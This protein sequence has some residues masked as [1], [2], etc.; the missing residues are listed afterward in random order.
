M[1]ILIT[2]FSYLPERHGISSV[3]KYLAE[4]LV[5][6]GYEVGVATCQNNQKVGNNE[7]INGVDVHRFA[8]YGNIF[9]KIK[10][11]V[12]SYIKFVKDYGQDVLLME[13][14]QCLTTDVLLPILKDLKCKVVIH[15][16]GAPGLYSNPFKIEGDIKHTIGHTYNWAYWKYYYLYTFKKYA[17]YIDASISCSVCAS[18]LPYFTKYI[19]KNFILENSADDIFFRDDNYEDNIYNTLGIKSSNYILNIATLCDRKNQLLLIDVFAKAKLQDCALVI[20]GTEKNDYY[21]KLVKKACRVSMCYGCEIKIFDKSIPRTMFPSIIRDAKLFVVTS[22]WEEY[23]IT[24][25]ETMAIGTPFLSTPVGNAHT[26][27]GGVTSRSNKELPILLNTLYSDNRRLKRM[28]IMAKEYAKMNNMPS[29]II[30]DLIKI[31]NETV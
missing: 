1:R 16:H 29:A 14:L 27:P 8:F 9:K 6:A 17:N 19:K 23:P 21:H 13:C 22:K 5:K 24:L 12:Q 18:D 20:I 15:A 10:G 30:S 7:T 11:D 3:T 25:V 28:G 26:L 4:G 31:F 2:S